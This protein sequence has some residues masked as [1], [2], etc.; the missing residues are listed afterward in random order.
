MRTRCHLSTKSVHCSCYPTSNV[1]KKCHYSRRWLL[2]A[3][4]VVNNNEVIWLRYSPIKYLVE[5]S[6]CSLSINTDVSV[7][8]IKHL[9]PLQNPVS[10]KGFAEFTNVS[11]YLYFGSVQSYIARLILCFYMILCLCR[12]RHEPILCDLCCFCR[13]YLVKKFHVR[14]G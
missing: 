13:W 9:L 5:N 1:N 7:S 14:E 2:P 6:V 8:A 12:I 3:V 4:K 11:F 10:M